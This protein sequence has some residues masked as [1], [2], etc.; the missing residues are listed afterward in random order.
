MP[1]TAPPRRAPDPHNM[2]RSKVHTDR[3]DRRGVAV[4]QRSRVRPPCQSS[5]RPALVGAEKGAAKDGPVGESATPY[6]AL[7]HRHDSDPAQRPRRQVVTMPRG[8]CRRGVRPRPV[9]QTISGAA[10]SH[11]DR[12]GTRYR[13][14]SVMARGSVDRYAYQ[15]VGH[16]FI[17]HTPGAGERATVLASGDWHRGK[18]WGHLL[19]QAFPVGGF[20]VRGDRGSEL[21]ADV[22]G[23]PGGDAWAAMSKFWTP[24]NSKRRI[25][26]ASDCVAPR[27]LRQRQLAGDGQL[28]QFAKLTQRHRGR[29]CG[30]ERVTI[31][32][33]SRR[34][35]AGS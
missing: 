7:S 14:G 34:D 3:G 24:A 1:D 19:K 16:E 12:D 25:S 20:G 4:P 9:F 5:A 33:R 23:Q 28:G 30:L 2:I 35:H 17:V 11:R 8:R 21:A 29:C 32:S 13:A 6:C 10:R 26:G 22:G 15:Q 27:R 31:A 18:S